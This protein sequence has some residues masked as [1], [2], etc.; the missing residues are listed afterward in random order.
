MHDAFLY[1]RKDGKVNSERFCQHERDPKIGFVIPIPVK[2]ISFLARVA[3]KI[4]YT[5][6]RVTFV[7]MCV[8][9]K[10]TTN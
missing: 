4:S 1:I 2:N 3:A 6:F 8:S 10:I 7:V 5:N 9:M